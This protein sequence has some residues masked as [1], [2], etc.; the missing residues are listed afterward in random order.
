M[1]DCDIIYLLHGFT[2][3]G[4]SM[5]ELK[6]HLEEKFEVRTPNLPGHQ[7]NQNLPIES[8]TIDGF[9]EKFESEVGKKK[10]VLCGYS[11]GA[12]VALLLVLRK[13]NLIK[14]LILISGFYGYKNEIEKS[15]RKVEDYALAN[16]LRQ[17]GIQWFVDYWENLELWSSQK[18]I[19]F[20][21]KMEQKW[22]RL[23]RSVLGLADSL[24]K[25][26]RGS[27][28]Y[29]GDELAEILVDTDIIV[30]ELDRKH[31][32]IG[33]ELTKKIKN[34]RLHQIREV[35]HAVHYEDVEEVSK[36]ILNEKN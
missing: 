6:S 33:S 27:M 24:E 18:N 14:R 3:C 22:L 13:P 26:G 31:C 29:L 15:K 8:D 21:K 35:G 10:V 28:P 16:K 17:N 23:D 2:G 9:I 20:R 1:S 12:R 34:S 32:E 19:D 7:S 30:G 5:I 4:D 11:L 36:I 25:F